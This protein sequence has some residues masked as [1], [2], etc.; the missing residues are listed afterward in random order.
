MICL[1]WILTSNILCSSS[2]LFSVEPTVGKTRL[3][4]ILK[5]LTTKKGQV[6]DLTSCQVSCLNV[7]YTHTTHAAQ[8]ERTR[9]HVYTL[10]SFFV[11]F[12]PLKAAHYVGKSTYS[13]FISEG[14]S[15]IYE[16]LE[17]C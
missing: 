12:L 3:E 14:P 1:T 7:Q 5:Q 16:M 6:G 8:L 17:I 9:I 13:Y 10:F 2:N 15:Y 4:T 11:F